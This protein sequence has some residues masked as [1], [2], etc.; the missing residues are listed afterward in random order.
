MEVLP[1]VLR[2]RHSIK[3]FQSTAKRIITVLQEINMVSNYQIRSIASKIKKKAI[4]TFQVEYY[5]LL[6]WEKI[7]GQC[8]R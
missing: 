2:P 3:H 1:I 8:S 5:N 6:G 4:E 7:L